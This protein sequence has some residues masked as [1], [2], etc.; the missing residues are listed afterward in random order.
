MGWV[1]TGSRPSSAT[2]MSQVPDLFHDLC[3]LHAKCPFPPPHPAP[4]SPP[5][6]PLK[7]R[8]RE[9]E[10]EDAGQREGRAEVLEEAEWGLPGVENSMLRGS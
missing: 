8:D 4:G 5:P 9:E 2:G 3:Q 6:P 7:E 1:E 10:G